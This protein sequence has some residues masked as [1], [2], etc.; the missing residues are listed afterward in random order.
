M[1]N[2]EKI[3]KR[4]IEENEVENKWIKQKDIL[5]P[6]KDIEDHSSIQNSDT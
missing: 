1:K 5:L 6:K 2:G 3:E 4:E